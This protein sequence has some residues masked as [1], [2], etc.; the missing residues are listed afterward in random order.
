MQATGQ[1]LLRNKHVEERV[2]ATRFRLQAREAP[3]YGGKGAMSV[4]VGVQ[5]P[6]RS[7][8]TMSTK[9]LDDSG[10]DSSHVRC[11]FRHFLISD[12]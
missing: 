12:H 11:T 3:R 6:P 7:D 1:K 2:T 8:R 10:G 9:N 5:V 4:E